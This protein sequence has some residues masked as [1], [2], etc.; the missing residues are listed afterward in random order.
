M[1]ENLSNPLLKLMGDLLRLIGE[2]C[3]YAEHAMVMIQDYMVDHDYPTETVLDV[4]TRFSFLASL[5]P[6]SDSS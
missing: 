2:R 1:T 5:D 4:L 3:M 6:P